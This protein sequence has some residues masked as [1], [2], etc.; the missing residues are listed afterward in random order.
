MNMLGNK[1]STEENLALAITPNSYATSCQNMVHEANMLLPLKFGDNP[2]QDPVCARELGE[3][4][5][6][7]AKLKKGMNMMENKKSTEEN[8]A[9]A[10]TPNSYAASYQNMVD[11]A[12]MLLPLKEKYMGLMESKE[13]L[14]GQLV[15]IG[16]SLRGVEEEMGKLNSSVEATNALL[17]MGLTTQTESD[18]TVIV[19]SDEEKDICEAVARKRRSSILVR[20]E[21]KGKASQNER[22][23]SGFRMIHGKKE[24]EMGQWEAGKQ[25]Q[26]QQR[27]YSSPSS[28]RT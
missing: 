20:S 26:Q 1:K 6:E 13:K 8:L 23:K 16:I 10:I 9:L 3:L 2:T 4:R 11:E 17:L 22:L 15:E 21:D 12:N 7:I 28:P 27:G 24:K 14:E 18:K 5:E 19:I 25:Q